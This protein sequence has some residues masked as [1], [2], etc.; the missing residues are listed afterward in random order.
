EWKVPA[1]EIT[2]EKGV[3]RHKSGQAGRFG[4][5]AA[6]AAVQPVPENPA[7]KDPSA[8]RLIGTTLPRL[9]SKAKTDG[10]AQYALDVRRPG[11]LTALVARAPRFGA[12][13]KSVD[14][15]AAKAVPGVVQVVRIPSGVAV[16]ARDT[17]SAMKG[18]EA[19][20]LTW[21]DAGAERQSTESQ[22]AAYKAMADKPGL[23][24]S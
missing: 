1:G 16:V 18:R 10:S 17:W 7:L 11:Q 23:V 9:D 24:A 13:L 5:F 6:K 20:T 8:F 22:Q 4:T 21:D 19:L 3:M 14:D 12:T 15:T 2:V